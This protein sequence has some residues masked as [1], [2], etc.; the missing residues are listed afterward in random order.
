MANEQYYNA[1]IALLQGFFTDKKACLNNFLDYHLFRHSQALEYNSD[2]EKIQA[3][4][5]FYGVILGN[6]KAALANGQ[7]LYNQFPEGSVMVG[8]S[9]S[10]Y[11]D[12]KKNNKKPFQDA[13]FMADCA[14]RSILGLKRE[15]KITNNFFWARMDGK[16]NTITDVS[17]LSDTVK[18]YANRYQTDKIK[19]ELFDNWHLCHY[20]SNMRGW[21]VSYDLSLETLALHAEANRKPH[22]DKQRKEKMKAAREA[23]LRKLNS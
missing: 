17:E 3:S 4:A 6:P 9:K 12:Y 14:I 18:K 10:K 23:A 1:P 13:C 20:S 8:I 11:W 5:N 16:A 2:L 7:K 21:W 22:L 15:C 19:N